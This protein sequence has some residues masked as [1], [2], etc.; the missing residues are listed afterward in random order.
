MPF[1]IGSPGKSFLF[2]GY[3]WWIP[4]RLAFVIDMVLRNYL[5]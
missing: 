3:A 5:L 4:A 2:L 1:F